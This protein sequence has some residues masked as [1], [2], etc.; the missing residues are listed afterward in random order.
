[1]LKAVF[2]DLDNTI[3]LYD[4]LVFFDRFF[5]LLYKRFDDL[6]AFEDF[7][8]RVIVATL[9]LTGNNGEKTNRDCFLENVVAGH[10]MGQEEF[11]QRS[12]EFYENDFDQARPEVKK[13]E[14]LYT[15]LKELEQIGLRLVVASNPIYPRIAIEKRLVWV[16]VDPNDFELI[17]H[18]ENMNFVKPAPGYYQ[19]IC[20]MLGVLPENCLMIGNDP[21]NDMTAAGLNIRTFLTTDG[22]TTDYGS[23]SSKNDQQ[24]QN[25]TN[26]KPDFIGPLA[27]VIEVVRKL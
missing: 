26:L 24:E 27:N 4:E 1:M 3:A 25:S 22:G 15:V 19:Q 14:N 16:G 8:N 2:I 9:S 20:N 7:Q 12:M 13:P 21:Q 17:T 23:L 11:W 18:M 10:E 6:F 5:Q